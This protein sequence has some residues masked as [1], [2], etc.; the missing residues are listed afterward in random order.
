MLPPLLVGLAAPALLLFD[1][2]ECHDLAD[3]RT[4]ASP[5]SLRLPRLPNK[6][7]LLLLLCEVIRIRPAPCSSPY[8]KDTFVRGN[9]SAGAPSAGFF[10]LLLRVAGV[11]REAADWKTSLRVSLGCIR[12]S[13]SPSVSPLFLGEVR[14]GYEGKGEKYQPRRKDR[15]FTARVGLLISSST[16]CGTSHAFHSSP[17]RT[18]SI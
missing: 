2:R 4:V 16:V 17:T 12:F 7:L 8:N 11:G 10:F 14:S 5:S 1:D 9:W 3:R 13:V 6:L 15:R 18:A